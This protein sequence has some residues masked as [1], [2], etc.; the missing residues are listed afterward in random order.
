[1]PAMKKKVLPLLIIAFLVYYIA[2]NPTA[3][4]NAARS[5]GHTIHTV[6]TGLAE[7]ITKTVK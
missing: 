3:S 7:A 2:I 5:I 1:M 4:A 6:A